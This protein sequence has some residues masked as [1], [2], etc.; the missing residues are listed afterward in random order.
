MNNTAV[1]TELI[2]ATTGT[3][4]F[5]SP[6]TM[7]SGSG[8]ISLTGAGTINFNGTSPSLTFGGAT[9]PVFSEIAG[10]NIN[11]KHGLTTN[12][13]ALTFI[14]GSIAILTGNGAITPNAT[15]TFGNVIL[16]TGVTD[17][18]NSA[19]A[20]AIVASSFALA[21]GANFIGNQNL[22]V[23]GNWINNGGTI[24]TGSY[25]IMMNGAAQT[26]G[27][28]SSTTFNTL[29]IGNN[30]V[31]ANVVCTMNNNTTCGALVFNGFTN[32]RNLTVAA[33]TT[34]TV[35]GDATLNQP[36]AGVT[37][38]LA[39]NTGTC[40]IGGN[41][42][43]IGASNTANFVAKVAVTTGSLALT[44]TVNWMANTAVTTEVIS[45]STGTVT[46]NSPLSMGTGSGTFNVTGAATVNFNGSSA[47]SFNFGGAATSPVF[48]TAAGCHYQLS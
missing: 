27:G 25:A 4:T 21:S 44:G 40:N 9:S 31:A 1:A 5:N 42:N 7:G 36:T 13:T 14:A 24:N 20:S 46:F 12:T 11:F 35:T 2:T 28:S 43:F 37:N 15:I 47:P 8:T 22:E 18:L 45:V 38:T 10:S 48:T 3:L 34:L 23:R 19:V 33:G 32:S 39:V 41:L 26:I 16:N 6:I 17:T 30:S 29:Q